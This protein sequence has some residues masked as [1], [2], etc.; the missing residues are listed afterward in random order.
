MIPELS[1]EEKSRPYKCFVLGIIGGANSGKTVL[2]TNLKRVFEQE[3][4]S[5]AILKEVSKFFVLA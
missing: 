1:L 3:N 2:A 5:V 4:Y